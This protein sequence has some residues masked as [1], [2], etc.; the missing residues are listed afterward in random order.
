MS[1]RYPEYGVRVRAGRPTTSDDSAAGFVVGDR[2]Y[3]TDNRAL[4]ICRDATAGDPWWV[5][6]NRAGWVQKVPLTLYGKLLAWWDLNETSGPAV[7][8]TGVFNTMLAYSPRTGIVPITRAGKTSTYARRFTQADGSSS[9]NQYLKIG[10]PVGL[11]LRDMHCYAW[12]NL[13]AKGTYQQYFTWRNGNGGQ[14]VFYL[15]YHWDTDRHIFLVTADGSTNVNVQAMTFGSPPTDSW[16]F[17][18]SYV[19]STAG[20]IG[21]AVNNGSYDTNTFAGPIYQNASTVSMMI[22]G[23]DVAGSIFTPDG[24]MQGVALFNT[25]LTTAERNALWNSGNGARMEGL[26]KA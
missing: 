10:C 21:I 12:V 4:W 2:I 1:Y 8:R 9:L 13:R 15:G 26:G 16:Q 3:D 17:V 20:Q 19:D 24:A 25:K 23:Q 5:P 7:E 18:E 11:D 14:N 22:G 6:V